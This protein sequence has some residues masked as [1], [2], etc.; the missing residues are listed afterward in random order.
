MIGY[1]GKNLSSRQLKNGTKKVMLRVSTSY[2]KKVKEKPVNVT[3]WHDVVAWGKR[4]EYA[5]KCFV[6]GSRILVNGS[7]VYRTY[8]DRTGHTRYVTEI[9]AHSLM[10]LDR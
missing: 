5:E 6:K 3:V 8:P 7:I 4:A 9:E 10:N 2:L 1:V